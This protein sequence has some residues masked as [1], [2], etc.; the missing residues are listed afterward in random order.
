MCDKLNIKW[1]RPKRCKL[2]NGKSYLPDFYLPEYNVYTD[3]KSVF[4]LKHYNKCQLDKIA[5]FE[6]EFKTSVII[7]WDCELTNWNDMLIQ[8]KSGS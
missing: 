2:S 6:T 8:I 1:Q 3:P 5:L 4:W 7:F